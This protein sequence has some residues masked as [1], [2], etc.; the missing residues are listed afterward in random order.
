MPSYLEAAHGPKS[1]LLTR[2]H[3]RIG[4]LYLVAISFFFVL[5]GL[6]AVFIRAELATPQGDMFSSDVY[7]R[8]FT[9][10]GILMVFFFLIPSIP[11]VLGNFLLPVMIGAKDLAFPRLNLASW[12]L[13]MIGGLMTFGSLLTGGIDTGWTFYTPLSTTFAQG[14]VVLTAVGIFVAGFSSILT[15][16]N[17]I[18]TIHRMRAPG[19]TWF[20]LPSSSGPTTRR[21]S[22]RSSGRRSS[23]SRF[24]SSGRAA[25]PHRSLRPEV[26]RRPA[27]LPAPLLGST[28][29]PPSTS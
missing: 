3:K 21:A 25:L 7:N 13:Y 19:M 2:D 12:Y 6:M 4:I 11:A 8:L 18:V 23:P 1:W 29:T 28:R 26:R 15:G 9:M 16:L 27:P 17:F 24:S 20:R 14:Q 10:H 22:S 5:G